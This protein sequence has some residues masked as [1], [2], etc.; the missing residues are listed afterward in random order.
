MQITYLV[1][2][3]IVAYI[4][5]AIN[6]AFITAIPDKYIPFQNVIIGFVSCL[7]CYFGGIIPTFLESLVL[8]LL[9]TMGAGGTYDLINMN[10]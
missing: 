1:I 8:C 3:G 6:K 7:I 4:L 9:A 2:I 10:K 5:G